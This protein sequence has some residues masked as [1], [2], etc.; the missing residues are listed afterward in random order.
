MASAA[1]MATRIASAADSVETP[2]AR[3]ANDAGASALGTDSDWDTWLRRGQR[4]HGVPELRVRALRAGVL[5]VFLLDVHLP[6]IERLAEDVARREQ[7]RQHRVVLVVV[8][9]H[10]VAAD[11]LQVGD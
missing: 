3:A 5:M 9:V 2:R 7:A 8:L 10:A 4:L 1:E 6:E 11:E